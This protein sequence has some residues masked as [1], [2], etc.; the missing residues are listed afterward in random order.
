[1]NVNSEP[2]SIAFDPTKFKELVVYIAKHSEDDPTF[3]SIKLNKVLYYAD[4]AAYRNLGHPIT[5]AS[6]R[7]LREGPVP[8]EFL[9][10][11]AD[12][13]ETGDASIEE[14]PY[15]TGVQKRL[16]IRKERNPDYELFTPPER[17]LID[18]IIAYFHGKTARETSDFSHREPGWILAEDFE[19]I[20]YPTA[21]LSSEPLDQDAEEAARL[22]ARRRG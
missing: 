11:R 5:G 14:R 15:F 2:H 7:K 22:F 20:P 1:M 10:A 9:A 13:V 8:N 12:L 6:Y 18:A 17:D 4:F 19:D 21:W 16:A 3:G